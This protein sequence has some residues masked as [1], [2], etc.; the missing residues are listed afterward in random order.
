[1]IELPEV[2]KTVTTAIEQNGR[3]LGQ[4][5]PTLDRRAKDQPRPDCRTPIEKIFHLGGSCYVCE[6]CRPAG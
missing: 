3:V 2:V 5:V 4:Y 1:M 6:G